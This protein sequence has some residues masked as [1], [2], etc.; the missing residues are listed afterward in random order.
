MPFHYAEFRYAEC[1]LFTIM[2]LCPSIMLNVIMLSV[3]MLS[4]VILSVVMLSVVMLSVV[5]PMWELGGYK[6]I[7]LQHHNND[8]ERKMF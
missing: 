8:Y 5:I 7:S 4:V 1:V 3:V 2:P 6:F